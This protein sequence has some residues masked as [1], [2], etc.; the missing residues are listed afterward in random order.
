MTVP[1]NARA[2]AVSSVSRS[3]TRRAPALPPATG[4]RY[5]V[6]DP[7]LPPDLAREMVRLCEGFGSYG[8]YS[9]EGTADD[10]GSG[11]SQRYD[12]AQNFVRSG[13][14][15]GRATGRKAAGQGLLAGGQCPQDLIFGD[16]VSRQCR[17]GAQGQCGADGQNCGD[18]S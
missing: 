11:L 13:G 5:R 18:R 10:M 1:V 7:L 17:A 14:R 15:L 2:T 12:A 3:S 9:E 16:L 4:A 6:F 8:A